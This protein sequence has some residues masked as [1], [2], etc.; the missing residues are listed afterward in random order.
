MS[1]R[2]A[3]NAHPCDLRGGGRC[4]RVAPGAS[5]FGQVRSGAQLIDKPG[6][7]TGGEVYPRRLVADDQ[8]ETR[9]RVDD[10]ARRRR[11][12][13]RSPAC[14]RSA[15]WG[16]CGSH[17]LPRSSFDLAVQ[18][19]P[20]REIERLPELADAPL[21]GARHQ[22]PHGRNRPGGRLQ[23]RPRVLSCRSPPTIFARIHADRP[24]RL[25]DATRTAAEC[26]PRRSGIG[27]VQRGLS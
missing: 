25:A 18:L 24:I 3:R 27:Y 13:R 21:C 16:S 14:S 15:D 22:C 5:G 26:A 19:R 11:R 6:Y 9:P 12:P 7:G 1:Q 4:W 10:H 17:I 2:S 8:S 20:A 23:R